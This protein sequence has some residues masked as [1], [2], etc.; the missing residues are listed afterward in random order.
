MRRAGRVHGL[1]FA[2]AAI[3]LV[4]LSIAGR[5]TYGLMRTDSLVA[6]LR[7]ANIPQV[8]EVV[9]QIGSYRRWADPQLKEADAQAADGSAEQLRFKLALL[10]VDAS[11][12][13]YVYRRL[14]DAPPEEVAVLRDALAPRKAAIVERLWSVTQQPAKDSAAE[15]LRAASALAAY[16][17]DDPRW[18]KIQETV[19]NDFVASPAVYLQTWLEA[20]RPVREKL[21]SPLSA[22]FRD[23][24]RSETER[25]LATDILADYAADRPQTL[26]ELLL[27]AD[28]K[29]FIV[30]FPKLERAGD[31]ATPLLLLELAKQLPADPA[32]ADREKL[33]KRR[34]NAGVAMF[35]L[36]QPDKVWTMLQQNRDPRVR[37]YLID[38]F[39]PLGCDA[40]AI[41]KRLDDET[42]V[43]ARRALLLSLGEFNEQQ[44]PANKRE[45]VL[46]KLQA[47]YRTADDPGLRSGRLAAATNRPI[48]TSPKSRWR[49]CQRQRPARTSFVGHQG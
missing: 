45:T 3:L 27:D 1:R 49:S 37:S 36:G 43:I 31:A 14:L 15:R 34:T 7:S 39:G 22:V 9:R 42:D 25:A 20:L 48:P 4:G 30:V 46:S 18:N 6:R 11:Q 41:V 8:P 47:I 29:Q 10:P 38:R 21:L 13:D 32:E 35:K 26:A 5:Q 12:T 16:A 19:A 40:G 17:P 28:E 24:R 2:V 44:W 23:P 33:G